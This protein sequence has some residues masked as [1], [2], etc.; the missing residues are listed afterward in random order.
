MVN[1]T[2][3]ENI[4]NQG[5]KMWIKEYRKAIDIDVEFEDGFISYN[6]RY[7]DFK[8][9]AILNLKYKKSKK[10]HSRNSLDKKIYGNGYIGIGDE[11]CTINILMYKCW[12]SMIERCFS[13][14]YKEKQPTYKDVTCC[15]K[16]LNYQ[17]FAKWYYD[18]FYQIENERMELDKDILLKGNKIYSPDT[19]IFVP[20]RINSL[21][22]K[23]DKARR[24]N[25]IGVNYRKD[26]GKYVARC[27]I[28]NSNMKNE[29]IYLG[30]Y[31]TSNEAFN[32]YKQFKENYIKQV[33]DKYKNKIPNKL[34]IALYNW[35]VEITD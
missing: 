27:N 21:F 16:W 5:L 9:G 7:G 31:L 26:N 17:N 2:G 1:R 14:K 4:N 25:P 12:E 32:V 15:D 11:T 23:C 24:D 20:S 34:Y 18:N 13:E 29:R 28:L 30:Q 6:K 33:A 19:C 3:E 10:C 8:N 22:V 35:I